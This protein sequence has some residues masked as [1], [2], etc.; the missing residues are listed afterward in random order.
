MI[1]NILHDAIS[2][3]FGLVL[4]TPSYLHAKQLRRKLYAAREKLR[5]QGNNEF[6]CLSFIPQSNG[7][8]WLIRRDVKPEKVLPEFTSRPLLREELPPRILARGKRKSG[9]LTV[10]ELS[11]LGRKQ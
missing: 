10:W 7:E 3:K 6:D 11:Q 9:L 1:G 5:L 8:L 2:A 4:V